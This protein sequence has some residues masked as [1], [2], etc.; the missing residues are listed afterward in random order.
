MSCEETIFTTQEA[1]KTLLQQNGHAFL[2]LF[3]VEK[4]FDSVEHPVLLKCLFDAGVNGKGWRLMKSWYEGSSLSVKISG[5]ISTPISIEHGV[6]QGSV[7]S[8]LLFIVLMDGLGYRFVL[9]RAGTS[10][11]GI[12]VGAWWVTC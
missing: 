12:Y 1:I 4:A 11:D 7:L 9:E 8:P 6:R 5:D 2:T 3:D 10:I